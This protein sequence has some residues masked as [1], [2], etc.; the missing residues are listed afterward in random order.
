MS[1]QACGS[2]RLLLQGGGCQKVP[3]VT[4]TRPVWNASGNFKADDQSS[5][6]P[7]AKP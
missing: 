5:V 4:S 2:I 3:S 7:Q 6:K 1:P